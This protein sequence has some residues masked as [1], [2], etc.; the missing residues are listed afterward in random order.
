M[1]ESLRKIVIAPVIGGI[2][3]GCV[4]LGATAPKSVEV[5]PPSDFTCSVRLLASTECE[6]DTMGWIGSAEDGRFV[7]VKV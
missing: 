2:I 4:A 3:L 5:Y 6:E 1:R 7:S